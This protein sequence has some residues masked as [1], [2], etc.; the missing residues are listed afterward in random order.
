MVGVNVPIPVPV[1]Y[2][3]FGGWKDS[4]FGD[5]HIYGNDGIALL[6]PR[7]GRH[8]PLARPGG[9]PGGRRPG[10]PAQPLR[11][12]E[13]ASAPVSGRR[14]GRAP[15]PRATASS[16]LVGRQRLL[17]ASAVPRAVRTGADRARRARSVSRRTTGAL[18]QPSSLLPACAP[19]DRPADAPNLLAPSRTTP[20]V[21]RPVP[22]SPGGG[23][24]R[25]AAASDAGRP[26][27]LTYGS[28]TARTRCAAPAAPALVAVVAALAVLSSAP[29]PGPPSPDDAPAVH[30]A[31]RMMEMNGG[32]RID[33]SYF[34]AGRPE[35]PARRPARARFRRQQERRARP[36]GEAGPRRVRRPDLVRPR[37]RQVD[38]GDRAQRPRRPRS[39]TSPADRLAGRRAPR[40]SSTRPA[41]R[42]S[43]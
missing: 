36:G 20:A 14:L 37:L 1:G 8:H 29:A 23:R 27:P 38:R 9:R 40:S 21:R 13:P 12:P 3:S 10:L 25:P 5:H 7:Q 33:T 43:A 42:A 15:E 32:V 34:T 6:H 28:T 16:Y 41:T 31:D 2:H 30:R 18:L 11:H 4:L 26:V 19:S 17:G 39:R 22:S 35:P 24:F